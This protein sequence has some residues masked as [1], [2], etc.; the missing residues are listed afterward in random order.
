MKSVQ[1]FLA[2]LLVFCGLFACQ[3]AENA[4]YNSKSSAISTESDAIAYNA[5]TAAQPENLATSVVAKVSRIDSLRKLIRTAEIKGK[6]NDVVKTTL[7]IENI[8]SQ[9]N[10]FVISSK[11]DND[12]NT[13]SSPISLDSAIEITNATLRSELVIRVPFR[14][15]DTTLRAIGK[16]IEFFDHRNIAVIDVTLD[17]IEQE[18][19]RKRNEALTGQMT[20]IGAQAGNTTTRIEATDR[21][22]QAR[23]AAQ[24]AWLEQQRIADKV[25]YSNV[26]INIYERERVLTKMIANREKPVVEPSFGYRIAS[27]FSTGWGGMSTVL[28]GLLY[29]WPLY[30]VMGALYFILKKRKIIHG[31]N[32]VA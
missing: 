18:L 16:Q 10:G 7:S 15:L 19:A 6:V 22:A 2:I 20:A 28:I 13:H 27:A 3:N 23:V 9:Q 12:Y 17:D 31:T 14:Q 11:L 29:L 21:E 30:L 26:S 4:P 5:N 32:N 25:Q 8:A 24:T 1:I